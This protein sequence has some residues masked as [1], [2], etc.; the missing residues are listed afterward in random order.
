MLSL[1]TSRRL[2]AARE[3]IF[4]SLKTMKKK[5][6]FAEQLFSDTSVIFLKELNEGNWKKFGEKN[7][8]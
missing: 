4:K 7:L 1:K 6:P 2:P 8:W 5:L 3:F